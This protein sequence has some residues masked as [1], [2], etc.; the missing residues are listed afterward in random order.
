MA[1]QRISELPAVATPASTD[2]FAVNQGGISKRQTR[3]QIHALESGEHLVLPRV[4]EPATPT[5]A[6]GDG[7]AGFYEEFEDTIALSRAGTKAWEFSS[8]LGRNAN[9]GS[10]FRNV[11]SSAIAPNILP[12]VSD[13]DTGIGHAGT[14]QLSLI[15]GAIEGIRLSETSS[16]VIMDSETH[17]GLTASTTQTQGN[18]AL[19]SSYNEI[20]TVGSANDTVTLPTAVAGRVCLVINNGANALRIFPAS[21]D[22]L[23]VGVDVATTL[24]PNNS[25]EW[26]AFDATTWFLEATSERQHVEMH[27]EDNTDVFVV[28]EAL[29][30]QC[31]HTNGLVL[32]DALGWTFDAGGAG[33]SFPIASIAD[34]AASGVDIEV[35][36]TGSHGLSVNDIVS[37]SNLTSAVYTGVFKVKA[38]IDA[39]K[40]EVVAVF[41]ATDTG[42]MDQAATLTAD[43]GSAGDYMLSWAS[44]ATTATNNETF[45]FKIYQNATKLTGTSARRKFGTAADFG[46]TSGVGVVTVVDGD[47]LSFIVNNEDSAG[48]LTIRHLTL[49]LIRL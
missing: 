15:A 7:G 17:A 32:G 21:G 38:V 49:V 23:G 41:T 6:F 18:G 40:Y 45:D 4:N 47:K 24:E 42:T 14:D 20:A 3:A 34:G 27:D 31:Y 11:D 29:N 2:E 16:H 30:D 1:D 5:L 22:N 10:A 44:S 8:I 39:T 37:H 35:T 12:A 9:S 26:L 19:L 28:T 43:T 33:T 48:N 25:N 13:L 36:T 46:S